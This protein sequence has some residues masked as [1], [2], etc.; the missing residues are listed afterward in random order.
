MQCWCGS[1]HF[2]AFMM[3]AISKTWTSCKLGLSILFSKKKLQSFYT[4]LCMVKIWNSII[5][6][7][8]FQKTSYKYVKNESVKLPWVL[9]STWG[10]IYA[11]FSHLKLYGVYLLQLFCKTW[12]EHCKWQTWNDT[13]WTLN[14]TSFLQLSL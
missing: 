13:L 2:I 4:Q 10:L 8:N 14:L 6:A 11:S 1:W 7:D 5:N 3:S 9:F 12:P